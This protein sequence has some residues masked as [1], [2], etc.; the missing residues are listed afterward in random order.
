MGYS[1]AFSDLR[2]QL[3]WCRSLIERID[4]KEKLLE[5][6]KVRL[7]CRRRRYK[8][9]QNGLG[10]PLKLDPC[11]A[12]ADVRARMVAQ[13]EVE[14]IARVLRCPLKTVLVDWIDWLDQ[15]WID[16]HWSESTAEIAR[17]KLR[18]LRRQFSR[19]TPSPNHG[20]VWNIKD[21]RAYL[22]VLA[23]HQAMRLTPFSQR[24]AEATW[25]QA[26][27]DRERA[28]W[29]AVGTLHAT[30]NLANLHRV[31]VYGVLLRTDCQLNSSVHDQ[32]AYRRA[33]PDHVDWLMTQINNT[34]VDDVS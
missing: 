17:N 26:L 24:K 22:Q 1:L 10:R 16:Q 30:P 34:F 3:S 14:V 33:W 27:E 6:D 18:R 12:K 9:K 13:V 23:L 21:G 11:L 7:E 20:R 4:E 32:D 8:A 28:R 15:H 19:R 31:A 2:R 25:D 29:L 5:Q